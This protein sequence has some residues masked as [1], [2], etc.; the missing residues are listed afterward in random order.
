MMIKLKHILSIAILVMCVFQVLY[1]WGSPDNTGWLIALIGWIEVT[2]Q[3]RKEG[4]TQ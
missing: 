1:T 2:F 4:I 3:Q